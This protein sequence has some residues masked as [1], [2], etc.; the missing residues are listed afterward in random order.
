MEIEYI[1]GIFFCFLFI[2]VIGMLDK[3]Y[4]KR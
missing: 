4:G 3:K 2:L 1:L